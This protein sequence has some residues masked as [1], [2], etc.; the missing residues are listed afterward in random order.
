MECRFSDQSRWLRVRVTV[1][2]GVGVSDAGAQPQA[3]PDSALD[4]ASASAPGRP[5]ARSLAQT[6]AHRIGQGSAA[7]S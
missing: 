1:M 6:Q 3:E 7:D 5:G 4:T 2:V